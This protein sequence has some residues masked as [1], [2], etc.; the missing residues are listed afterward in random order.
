MFSPCWIHHQLD[1]ECFYTISRRLCTGE[2]DLWAES[3]AVSTNLLVLRKIWYS[4]YAQCGNHD[5]RDG[6][7]LVD[8]CQPACRSPSARWHLGA[9]GATPNDARP[10]DLMERNLSFRT[11]T[12]SLKGNAR[13]LILTEL[14]C[15]RMLVFVL[16][17]PTLLLNKLLVPGL[18]STP[19]GAISHH[20]KGVYI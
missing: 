3:S 4:F 20:M 18:Y 8:W 2:G 11:R 19:Y 9:R 5:C 17:S 1:A 13:T 14:F 6:I 12:S 10:R 7:S 16:L 15:G